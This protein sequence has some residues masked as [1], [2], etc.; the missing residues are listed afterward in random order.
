MRY[1]LDTN[2][3]IYYATDTDRLSEDVF[4]AIREPDAMLYVSAETVRELIVAY[5]KRSFDTR[6]WK[7]AEEMVNAIE[8]DFF[9]DILPLQKE[10][11][12]TYAKLRP[13]VMEGHRDPSDHVI[14]S[15]AI[16][17]EM[18]LVSSDTLFPYYTEF[19]LELL[20]NENW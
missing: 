17:N 11:M 8:D 2:I 20:Y 15:H 1:L 5:D 10:H 3:F 12:R 4:D 9:I 16:T 14:I 6:R 7:T 19:G 13:Y 18:I